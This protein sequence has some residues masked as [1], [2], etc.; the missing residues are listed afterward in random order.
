MR[1][2]GDGS[3]EL[4]NAEVPPDTILPVLHQSSPAAPDVSVNASGGCS[5]ARRTGRH[6]SSL[7]APAAAPRRAASPRAGPVSEGATK[8][9]PDPHAD[10]K[11]PKAPST[12]GSA[13]AGAPPPPPRTLARRAY[14]WCFP[15]MR[16][17]DE[18]CANLN[19]R[20]LHLFHVDGAFR[21]VCIYVVKS[22]AFERLSLSLILANCVFLAMDSKDPDFASTR[23]GAMLRVA[24]WV[25]M[26]AFTVEMVVKIAAL[27][28]VGARGSYLRDPWNVIDFAVVVMGW[29]SLSP[30][31]Q[32]VSAMRSVRVLRPLRTITG[33]EG[34]RMLVSTLLSSLPMLLDVLILVAF[35]FLIFGTVAVQTFS[36]ALRRRCGEP[37]PGAFEDMVMVNVTTF[38]PIASGSAFCGDGII[39]LPASGAWFALNGVCAHNERL[40]RQSIARAPSR[41]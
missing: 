16:P 5:S 7:A 20:S 6:V 33:V 32:N 15:P 8:I 37:A 9:A 26:V 17:Y 36:G 14:A 4:A 38:R 40:C 1:E 19:A 31:I 3:T 28:L 11:A 41:P 12:S 39:Q 34:M 29:L 35:L 25:F 18:L 24:E 2:G 22:K 21:R 30:S 23:G 13:D 27:G 10:R